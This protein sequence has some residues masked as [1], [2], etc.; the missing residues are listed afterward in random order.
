VNDS[1]KETAS[2][3]LSYEI[4]M[5]AALCAEI[6]RRDRERSSLVSNALLEAALVHARLLIEFVAGRPDRSNPVQR[7]WSPKD[8][9]PTDF[10][11][12]WQPSAGVSLDQYLDL[13]DKHVVHLS[14]ARTTAGPP[15]WPVS[16][17]LDA[18]LFQLRLFANAAQREGSPFA[19]T[20]Q[21]ALTVA[22]QQ[23]HTPPDT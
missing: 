8:I 5:F 19:D 15:L 6:V 3:H 4:T 1:E 23:D 12:E 18:I 21:A 22:R 20:F 17:I 9:Q 11:T 10:L 13:A 16:R 2:G 7:S 14:L